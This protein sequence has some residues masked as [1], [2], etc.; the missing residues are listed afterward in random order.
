MLMMNVDECPYGH[1]EIVIG[2]VHTE[3]RWKRS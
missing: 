3:N 2:T 1:L